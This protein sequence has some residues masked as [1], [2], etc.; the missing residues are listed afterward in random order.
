[1]KI[2][3]THK[4]VNAGKHSDLVQYIYSAI[5]GNMKERFDNADQAELKVMEAE[6]LKLVDEFANRCFQKGLDLAS[7]E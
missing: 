7:K 5:Q 2:E 1:M 6:V 3:T 4:L